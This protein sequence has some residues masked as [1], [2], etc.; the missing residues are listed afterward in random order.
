[1]TTIDLTA[2][3]LQR[4]DADGAFDGV[5]LA[6]AASLPATAAELLRRIVTIFVASSS[7]RPVSA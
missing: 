5:Q 1:M 4:L 2:T 3:A 7:G 6:A